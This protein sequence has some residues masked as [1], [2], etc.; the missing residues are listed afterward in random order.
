MTGADRAAE[1]PNGGAH[2]KRAPF[3]AAA[4]KWRR[5]IKGQP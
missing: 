2:A 3:A 4:K 5:L 1:T